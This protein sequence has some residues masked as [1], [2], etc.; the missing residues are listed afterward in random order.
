[1]GFRVE[2][3]S[4]PAYELYV[5]LL[6]YIKRQTHRTL[7]LESGWAARVRARLAPRLA[8]ALDDLKE[9]CTLP[10]DLLAWQC[11]EKGDAAGFV[12]WLGRLAPADLHQRIGPY[13]GEPCTPGELSARRDQLVP[14]LAGWEEQYLRTLDPAIWAGLAA[15]AAAT[16]ARAAELAPEAAVE[17]AT[18]GVCLEPHPA[19]DRVILVPQHHFR[20]WNIPGRY[21][22]VIFILYPADLL[23]PAPDQPPPGLMRLT[24]ALADESRLRI[25]RYLGQAPRTFTEV[26]RYAGLAK[27]TV[28]H[29]LVALRASGLVRVHYPA[30]GGSERY[31]LRDG[32]LDTLG[33]RLAGYLK[34]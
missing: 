6:A 7:E 17:Q 21:R 30:D 1:M 29:H 9:P 23:P 13:V 11:P 25:L 32:A 12:Q 31:S 4:A 16:G 10:L 3:D 24:R 27:S 18:G 5:S 14:L 34:T 2:V 8:A 20:P 26:V 15:E 28:H 33:A 22:G 19:L